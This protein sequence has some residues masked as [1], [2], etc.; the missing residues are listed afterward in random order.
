MFRQIPKFSVIRASCFASRCFYGSKSSNATY[1]ASLL[2]EYDKTTNR[3]KK[4]R[5]RSRNDP[6]PSFK[7]AKAKKP[8][9]HINQTGKERDREA[10]KVVSDE[11]QSKYKSNNAIVILPTGNLEETQLS[12][13]SLT[14]NLDEHG[15]QVVGEKKDSKGRPVPLV[16][17]VD[18]QTAIKNY[19]DYLHQQVTR[20]FSSS[21]RKAINTSNVANKDPWKVI[22]V[23]WNISLQDLASQK[24]NEIEQMLN[25]GQ[26]VYILIG[27]KGVINKSIDNPEDLFND[28]HKREVSLDDIEALRR[29]KIVDTLDSMLEALP[30]SSIGNDGSIS[31]KIIYKIKA[32]PKKDDKDEKKRLKEL[33]KQERQEKIRLRTEK[34]RAE[35]KA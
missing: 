14:L 5:L 17:V 6:K 8:D 20:K 1:I 13:T 23:S 19:S 3:S 22:K 16:K 32:Q 28:Q 11:V 2:A 15:L 12:K 29:Q 4:P 26:N 21:F 24:C 33:K 35:S 34:K 10:L 7:G 25:K 31:D 18:R 30:T 9:R 27:S